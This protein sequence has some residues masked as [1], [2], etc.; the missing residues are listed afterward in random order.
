M[1]I[2]FSKLKFGVYARKSSEGE[3][4]QVQSI[5]SQ[6]SELNECAAKCGLKRFQS[7]TDSASAHKPNNR[8]G[9]ARMMEAIEKGEIDAILT[10]KADRLSRNSIEGGTLLY[11]L[12]KGAIKAIKTPFSCY[13]PTDNTLPLTIEFGMANQYS[14]DLSRNVKRGN[15][16][17]IENGGHCGVAPP[18]YL[19][20]KDNKTVFPDPDRFSQVRKMWDLYLSETHSVPQI[21]KV[22]KE[23]GFKTVRRKKIGGGNLAVSTL[24]GVLTNPF[25]YGQVTS[26]DNTNMGEHKPMITEAE[27][28]KVQEI[29][30]R[31]GRKGQT[32]YE[33]PFTGHIS[34]GECGSAITAEEKVKYACPKCRKQ[35][36]AKN[37]KPCHR[38]GH[39]LTTKEVAG[40]NWYKY[41]RCTKKKGSCGQKCLSASDLEKQFVDILSPLEIDPDFEAWALKWLKYLN[42]QEFDQNKTE[43]NLFLKKYQQAQNRVK[44]LIEMRADGELEKDEFLEL[45]SE[46]EG[47]RD[48]AKRILKEAEVKNKDWLSQA[49][50]SLD[51]VLGIQKRFSKGSVKEKKY[52]FSQIGSNFVLF[53]KILAL[54]VQKPYILYRDLKET[55]DTSIEPFRVQSGIEL[56]PDLKR[57]LSTWQAR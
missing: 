17:K 50:E 45:K 36:S 37:P 3:D 26:G 8:P 2:D 55:A 5:D 57:T 52:I 33:F 21:C 38:C 46:A 4:R 6:L 56:T 28:E 18:G 49:E 19:N 51:F 40:G 13:L 43:N 48:R 29:L 20:D 30:R 32:S 34:C 47:E 15:K 39:Q 23:W 24:Y 31:Q 1:D 11:L 16:T 53:D 14:R 41:Y 12:E 27:F 44:R 42:E 22:T 10:W 25:Y 54:E 7:F 9:F 35:H